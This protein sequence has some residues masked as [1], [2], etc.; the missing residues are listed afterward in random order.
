[1]NVAYRTLG[2]L[3]KMRFR[4]RFGSD[5]SIQR[6][7]ASRKQ[8][9]VC[10]CE[11]LRHG[12]RLKTFHIDGRPK[13]FYVHRLICEAF[14]GPCPP[15]NECRHDDGNKLNNAA[16][17]LSWGTKQENASDR[18]RHGTETRGTDQ[19]KAVLNES[20]VRSIR[21]DNRSNGEI[22]REL[23]VTRECVRDARSGKTWGWV[24]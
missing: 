15:L 5:G 3:D 24:V 10:A 1:M 11:K 4:Y 6:F 22:A 21:D 23:G 16:S 14:H 2:W 12:Y 8:W 9:E 19:R 17:N 7:I 18:T 13:D 20:L